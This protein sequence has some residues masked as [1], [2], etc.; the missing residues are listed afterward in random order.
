[1][2]GSRLRSATTLLLSTK[3]F[4]WTCSLPRFTIVRMWCIRAFVPII[5]NHFY[6]IQNGC[7]LSKWVWPWP[8]ATCIKLCS[9]SL[10]CHSYPLLR[11]R[12]LP[13]HIQWL[14]LESG[15]IILCIKCLCPTS[16]TQLYRNESLYEQAPDPS[17]WARVWQVRLDMWQLIAW[18]A[19]ATMCH[20]HLSH[21]ALQNVLSPWHDCLLS[22]DMKIQVVRLTGMQLSSRILRTAV[23]KTCV[24]EQLII[25]SP[26]TRP[27]IR[28]D[29][30]MNNYRLMHD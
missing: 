8:D 17:T 26:H 22:V 23:I 19:C 2:V 25:L 7:G 4:N 20:A 3:K 21:Q 5:P 12:G 15:G 16:G 13:V 30:A 18:Y 24:V 10:A 11:Q 6:K 28:A 9:L 1:M 14:I 29:S 27:C